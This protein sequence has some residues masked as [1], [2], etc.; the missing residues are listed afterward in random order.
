MLCSESVLTTCLNV[1][2]YNLT[3]RPI[4]CDWKEN[5]NLWHA[6]TKVKHLMLYLYFTGTGATAMPYAQRIKQDPTP[7]MLERHQLMPDGTIGEPGEIQPAEMPRLQAEDAQRKGVRMML[8]KKNPYR[9]PY[10]VSGGQPGGHSQQA[11][12]SQAAQASVIHGNLETESSVV[13]QPRVQQ[14]QEFVQQSDE[15]T[16]EQSTQ[17]SGPKGQFNCP[18][19]S[20]TY[21]DTPTLYKHIHED[22][23]TPRCS[24]RKARRKG[25]IIVDDDGSMHIVGE[26]NTLWELTEENIRRYRKAKRYQSRAPKYT[27]RR[28]YTQKEEGELFAEA[29]QLNDAVDSNETSFEESNVPEA[30]IHP[31]D[32]DVTLQI[33]QNGGQPVVT[34]RPAVAQVQQPTSTT[35]ADT[36]PVM[37]QGHEKTMETLDDKIAAAAKREFNCPRCPRLFTKSSELYIHLQQAHRTSGRGRGRGKGAYHQLQIVDNIGEE[38]VAEEGEV[39]QGQVVESGQLLQA[40]EQEVE[41]QVEYQDESQVVTRHPGEQQYGIQQVA[42]LQPGVV[43]QDVIEP[44]EVRPVT[45]VPVT[46]TQAVNPGIMVQEQQVI[47]GQQVTQVVLQQE[48]QQEVPQALPPAAT[49]HVQAV[50]EPSTLQ[51]AEQEEIVPSGEQVVGSDQEADLTVPQEGLE[52]GEIPSIKVS[53][54]GRPPKIKKE[55]SEIDTTPASPPPSEPEGRTLRGK[56]KAPEETISPPAAQASPAKRGRGR[57]PSKRGGKQ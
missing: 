41:I 46:T 39:F 37:L 17:Q 9:A 7:P 33:V 19:C 20:A 56:R 44:G 30:Q 13:V 51:I 38:G 24:T 2:F 29:E 42:A 53:R 1:T 47:D 16:V 32:T 11:G 54:R 31:A 23:G 43:S 28:S 48:P 26:Q 40:G 4:N 55:A 15:Y 5:L 25:T 22:H 3:S 12:H 50:P 52:E 21:D 35:P 27:P 10:S 34:S 57:P 18:F 36:K 8:P 45:T 6:F 49:M 14:H